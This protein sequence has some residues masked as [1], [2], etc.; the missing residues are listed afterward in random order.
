M[1]G[2]TARGSRPY[3]FW[4]VHIIVVV[5]VLVGLWWV[6]EH[7]DLVRYVEA[8]TEWLARVWLPLLALI[9]YANA[10]AAFWLWRL[11]RPV[12]RPSPFPDI[13]AAWEAAVESAERADVHFDRLPVFLIV[14]RPHGGDAA[15]FEAAR[16]KVMEY[17]A[18]G[19]PPVRVFAT[20][21]A[22]FVAVD[23]NSLLGGLAAWASATSETEEPP[24]DETPD[25][26]SD[27]IPTLAAATEAPPEP[28]AAP[29]PAVPLAKD[30]ARIATLTARFRHLCGLLRGTRR[31]LC[32]VNGILVLIP[33]ACT[34]SPALANQ[35]GFFA[36][37][38]L[39]TAAEVLQVRCPVVGVIC[40][41][42]QIPGFDEFLARVP[43]ARRKQRL[44]RK[45]PYAARLSVADRAA[46]IVE[47]VR[48][49]TTTLV[50]RLV[51]RVMPPVTEPAA[52][53]K[54]FQLA[55]AIHARTDAIV[56]VFTRVLAPEQNEAVLP[57][58]CFFA[59]TG[60]TAE[61]Q[62]FL[63]DVLAQLLDGQNF[64]AWTAAGRADEAATTRRTMLGYVSIALTTAAV[65]ALA[66][67][68]WP[69]T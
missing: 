31:P 57:A 47:S 27:Q 25:V 42:E 67:V 38:D 16:V 28:E 56:R 2:E 13:D 26:A 11:L 45:L 58:G 12:A 68:W 10:W 62:G 30:P 24:T 44:G 55:V 9:L 29:L 34:R 8:P 35:A 4:A 49:Q 52:N 36:A 41:A 14:G 59:A 21:D 3:V 22:L 15:L 43:V 64:V 40:D 37:E 32:P 69:R 65:I 39:R 5:A 53:A 63:T 48:W 17:S 23:E 6:N 1:I 18:A 61:R 20:K 19:D 50:P 33:E 46:L 60:P 7:F 66:I 51:Y 54:L